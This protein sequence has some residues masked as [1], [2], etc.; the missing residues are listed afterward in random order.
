MPQV[1]AGKK[2]GEVSKGKRAAAVKPIL[3]GNFILIL[4]ENQAANLLYELNSIFN[5]LRRQKPLL[6][7]VLD[8]GLGFGV[9]GLGFGDRKSVV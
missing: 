5:K 1:A 3:A 4:A 2:K 7:E 9:W 6:K 8:W